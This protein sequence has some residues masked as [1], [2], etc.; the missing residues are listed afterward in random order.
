MSYQQGHQ[1]EG[2]WEQIYTATHLGQHSIVLDHIL[3]ALAGK[4]EYVLWSTYIECAK[5]VHIHFE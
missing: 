5:T 4:V 2:S 3:D 1:L